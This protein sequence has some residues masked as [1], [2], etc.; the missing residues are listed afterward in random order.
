M[1][2][3]RPPKQRVSS[4]RRAP[5]LLGSQPHDLLRARGRRLQRIG[6]ERGFVPGVL[7]NPHGLP[8]ACDGIDDI[9][10][11]RGAR[12]VWLTDTGRPPHWLAFNVG[13]GLRIAIAIQVFDPLPPPRAMVS[14]QAALGFLDIF[15]DQGTIVGGGN[16]LLG[17]P[18]A[19]TSARPLGA[20]PCNYPGPAGGGLVG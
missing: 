12:A 8:L 5:Q 14:L 18:R 13:E 17:L 16:A 9:H 19:A 4:E 15:A 20:S 3:T 1:G 10:G 6:D 7:G 11:M 2:G